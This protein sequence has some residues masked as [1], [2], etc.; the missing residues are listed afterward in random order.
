MYVCIKEWIS[1]QHVGLLRVIAPLYLL[2]SKR[3]Q[4]RDV[5]NINKFR[6][7]ESCGSKRGI[8]NVLALSPFVLISMCRSRHSNLALIQEYTRRCANMFVKIYLFISIIGTSVGVYTTISSKA[9]NVTF[10]YM[11]G[12]RIYKSVSRK[13]YSIAFKS[14]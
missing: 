5:I 14:V 8:E 2:Q 11:K 1:F 13:Y 12:V 10:K 6:N 9:N 7:Y 4:L 3:R